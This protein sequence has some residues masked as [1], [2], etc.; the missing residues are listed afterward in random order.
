MSGHLSIHNIV[1]N[2][3]ERYCVCINIL[4]GSLS[5]RLCTFRDAWR[6]PTNLVRITK[7]ELPS[8]E[9]G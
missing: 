1:S 5:L 2:K 7:L 9:P 4:V 8:F 3:N 6:H